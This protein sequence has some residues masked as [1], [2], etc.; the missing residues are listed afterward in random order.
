MRKLLSIL[1]CF[2]IVIQLFSTNAY[3]IDNNRSDDLI[4]ENHYFK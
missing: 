4:P 1:L 2:T 3:S